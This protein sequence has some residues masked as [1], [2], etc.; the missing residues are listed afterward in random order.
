MNFF[1]SDSYLMGGYFD[2]LLVT[3]LQADY[4]LNDNWTLIA[5]SIAAG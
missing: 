2:P 3:G 4:K 5:E 1:Y